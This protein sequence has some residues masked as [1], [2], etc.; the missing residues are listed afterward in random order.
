MSFAL[1][2]APEE[3][4]WKIDIALESLTRQKV[5]AVDIQVFASEVANEEAIIGRCSTIAVRRAP[6]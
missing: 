5:I 3:F 2:L 6:N 1:S 4:Q